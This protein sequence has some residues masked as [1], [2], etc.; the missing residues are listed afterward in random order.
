[1][2]RFAFGL[3]APMDLAAHCVYL[4]QQIP[5]KPFSQIGEHV[6]FAFVLEGP[7][8]ARRL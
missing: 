4:T 3:W 1:M 6:S 7:P 2:Q 5:I 8:R